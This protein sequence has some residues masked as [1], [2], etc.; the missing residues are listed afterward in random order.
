M[1]YSYNWLKELSGVKEDPFKMADLLTMRSFELEKVEK[2]RL[3]IEKVVVGK[4]LKI[5]E[6]PQADRLQLVE[7]KVG[8]DNLKI[9]CGAWNIKI[10][11]KVPV[12]LV[13]AEL[14]GTATKENPN[15]GLKIKA[16]KIRGQESQGM[17]CAEDELGWGTDHNG[18]IILD[19]KAKVGELVTQPSKTED[20]IFEMKV[21]PDRSHDALSHLGVAR[22]LAV[23]KG[24]KIDY[25]FDGLKLPR[26]KLVKNYQLGINIKDKKLCSR[27]IGAIMKNV[28][29]KDSPKWIKERLELAGF[30]PINNVV[31]VTNY[32]MLELGQP[33]HAFDFKKIIS[34]SQSKSKKEKAK[35]IVRRAKPKETLRLLDGKKVIL[36]NS[37][38]LIANEDKPLALAGIMGGHDSE[39]TESTQTILLEAA[40]FEATNIRRSRTRLNFKTEASDRFEKG[41]D[42]N[43]CEKAI[44]RAIEILEHIAKAE[45]DNLVDI[46]PKKIK[47]WKIK[48]DLS[49]V[50][51]LLGESVP[52]R[53]AV[54]ILN[55][56]EIKTKN[57]SK[58][59]IIE[60]LI[61]T[62]RID[63]KTQEDLT[64]EIGRILGYDNIKPVALIEPIIPAKKNEII[65]FEQ[66]IR[67]RMIGLGFNEVYNYS[68]YARQE[69]IFCGLDKMKH[70]EVTNPMNPNQE[71]VRTSLIPNILKNIKEN[72]K[73]FEEI[74]IFEIGRTYFPDEH[75][76]LEKRILAVAE[77]LEK[78]KQADTFYTLKGVAENLL[79]S[80]GIYKKSVSLTSAK[81][82]KMI[83]PGRSAE[84]KVEGKKIG[85]IFEINPLVLK[86]YKIKKRVAVVEFDLRELLSVA[87]KP[88]IYQ[89]IQRYP[90]IT[91]D[92]SLRASQNNTVAEIINHIQKVAGELALDVRIFDIFKKGNETSFAFHL[93][94]GANNRT[95][96][97]SEVDALMKKIITELETKL[98]VKI[99]K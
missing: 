78:D 63:L 68:F 87:Q 14:P 76:I 16:T 46:Y 17:L 21:L 30:H 8:T 53:K 57:S 4:I 36:D 66:K 92:I 73:H 32:V 1:K 48:L 26:K 23:L 22:E 13:G 88:K 37:D 47:P 52:K 62:F 19:K 99:R 7:V 80:F 49:Y 51:R 50:S 95:L 5:K 71:L 18:I 28:E 96:E 34:S 38:L 2:V 40:S 74:D 75:K 10:G 41:L 33:L 11:D 61:P 98:K 45:L 86:A 83:H 9:V 79:E 25:D 85:N 39:I 59:D 12:A 56:L 72:L 35:I 65:S 89:P 67:E 24:K 6:H 43:F 94:F 84:I 93:E 91:R 69:A 60:C 64:E 27:Y 55:L 31:D 81:L 58:K 15:P 20:V 90:I 97:K 42:P 54:K 29:I 82:F 44:T 3:T 70:Y 77:V